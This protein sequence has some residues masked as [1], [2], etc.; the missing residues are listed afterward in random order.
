M[1]FMHTNLGGAIVIGTYTPEGATPLGKGKAEDL[2]RLRDQYAEKHDD[3]WFVPGIK[4]IKAA[5]VDS[6]FE[7]SA[8]ISA[9]ATKVRNAP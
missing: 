2:A 5:P 1:A 8:L 3:G 7:R 9:F 4:A 6:Y